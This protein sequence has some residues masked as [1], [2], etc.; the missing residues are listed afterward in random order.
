MPFQRQVTFVKVT[1]NPE[2]MLEHLFLLGGVTTIVLPLQQVAI[3][4][5]AMKIRMEITGPYA[6]VAVQPPSQVKIKDVVIFIF[7]YIYNSVSINFG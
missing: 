3:H 5:V 1:M 4:Q 2:T 7:K 6:F